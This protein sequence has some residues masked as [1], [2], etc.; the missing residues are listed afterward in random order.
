MKNFVSM[1]K[2]Y[3]YK[4][5]TELG[6]FGGELLPGLAMGIFSLAKLL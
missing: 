6:G 1:E 4:K 3:K 5:E 2:L